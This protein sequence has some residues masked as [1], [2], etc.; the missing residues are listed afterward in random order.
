MIWAGLGGSIA[1]E[2]FRPES[3]QDVMGV[4]ERIARFRDLHHLQDWARR[5]IEALKN[6]S[7]KQGRATP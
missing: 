5:P 1:R 6:A 3:V 4:L 7:T 2:V